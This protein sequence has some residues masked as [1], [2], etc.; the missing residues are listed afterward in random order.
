[1]GYNDMLVCMQDGDI[2]IAWGSRHRVRSDFK[3]IAGVNATCFFDAKNAIDRNFAVRE[4]ASGG[5]PAG[6]WLMAPQC[7]EDR[8]G[9][10][11][12]D[13]EYGGLGRHNQILVLAGEPQQR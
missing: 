3:A 1:V 12:S 11:L 9:C 6:T 4:Q 7:R 13:H 8:S 10:V 2:A 5:S